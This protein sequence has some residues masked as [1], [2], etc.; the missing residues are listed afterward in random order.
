MKFNTENNKNGNYLFSV[1]AILSGILIFSTTGLRNNFEVLVLFFAICL[2]SL[3]GIFKS[4]DQF[5]FSLNKTFH[6]FYYFF[7]GIAPAIQYKH[8]SS[9]FNAPQLGELDYLKGGIILLLILIL[10]ILIYH[11]TFNYFSRNKTSLQIVEEKADDIRWY[12]VISGI[13]LI[14]L[15]VLVN[16]NFQLLFFRPEA[17]FLKE[18][19]NFGLIGYTILLILRPIPLIILLRYMLFGN[20][21]K[22]HM[23][24]LGILALLSAFPFSLSRGLVAAYYIP[25]L[26]FFPFV[27][28]YKYVYTLSYFIGVFFVFPVLNFFRSSNN[29][30]YLGI[31]SFKT[32]H[33]DSFQNFI[34]IINEEIISG[35]RQLLGA[36]LFFVQESTWTGRPKGTGTLLGEQL[37]FNHLNVAMPYF[38][39]GYVNFGYAGILLFLILITVFNSYLDTRFF[40]NT[41]TVFFKI[42]YLFLLG[43]EFYILRGDLSSSIKKGVSFVIAL[44]A[45]HYVIK[46][47]RKFNFQNNNE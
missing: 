23:F 34:L 14:A 9:F 39:E 15:I 21:T 17:N 24:F 25:F 45:I 44:I 41:T 33:F 10:Y 31:E 3:Y 1:L 26:L 11:Y 42:V 13:S 46:I 22:K 12:Y 19:T 40:K 20:I 28:A 27:K 16:F 6:L 29:G 2:L 8:E 47:M 36:I 43:F 38:G 32:G 35:G 30:I 7:F 37:N 5:S 4:V 18:H